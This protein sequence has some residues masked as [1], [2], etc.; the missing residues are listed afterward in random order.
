MR[1]NIQNSTA[2]FEIKHAHVDQVRYQTRVDVTLDTLHE[3]YEER[4]RGQQKRNAPA[5]SRVWGAS[6]PICVYPGGVGASDE[7]EIRQRKDETAELVAEMDSVSDFGSGQRRAIKA[8][9]IQKSANCHVTQS[10]EPSEH[11]RTGSW[12]THL[13]PMRARGQ[14][15]AD[16]FEEPPPGGFEHDRER[17]HHNERREGKPEE[18]PRRW[19]DTVRSYTRER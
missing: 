17:V 3:T 13:D 19:S 6:P 2:T 4:K 10:D 5:R 15:F 1:T 7:V 14:Q 11:E 8:Y 12:V 18:R 9:P 16:I